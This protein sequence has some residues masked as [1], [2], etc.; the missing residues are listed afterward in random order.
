MIE[1]SIFDNKYNKTIMSKLRTIYIMVIDIRVF[2]TYK[3]LKCI[4]N[5]FSFYNLKSQI[6]PCHQQF[7]I[8]MRKR[9]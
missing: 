2:V 1:K 8:N 7:S 9:E 5:F 6:S 4:C 3:I